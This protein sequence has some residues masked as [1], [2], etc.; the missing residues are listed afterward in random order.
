MRRYVA[1]FLHG[2]AYLFGDEVDARAALVTSANLTAAGM[3]Q[4]LEL[5]LVHYDPEVAKRAVN[6]FDALWE[7]ATDYK[8]DL[9]ELLFPDVGLLDPRTVYL[10]ALL[11]LFGDQ[12]DEDQEPPQS[13]TLAP[14]QEDGFR[15]ALSIVNRHR[16]VVFADG[17]GTGKTEIGMAFVEEYAVRRGQH[18]LIVVPAQLVEQWDARLNRTRLPAQVI[19][20][21]AFAAD[22]QLV[23]P[24]VTH[25]RRVLSNDKDAYRLIIFDEAHALRN[26]GTTWYGAMSRLLGGQEKGPTAPDRNAHQQR[27]MGPVPHGHGLRPS[28]PGLRRARNLVSPPPLPECRGQRTRPG[29]PEP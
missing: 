2:K 11:E 6:W 23:N 17:V 13:V 8:D 7:E 1:K 14:F 12:L 27:A 18:V 4:N 26:P 5:G 15:R 19:S 25:R 29:K 9:Y 21:H 20:Y 22:D 16:G 10:R 24:D 28:R 3:W